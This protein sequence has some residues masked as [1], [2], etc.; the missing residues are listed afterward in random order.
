MMCTSCGN[1]SRVVETR[2][3]ESAP[4]TWTGKIKKA[5]EVA[6]WYTSDVVMRK[7]VCASGHLWYTVELSVGDAQ[8]MIE[9][10]MP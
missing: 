6:T 8:K 7:R 1:P 5:S 3:P 4:S 10:G 2:H 9:E